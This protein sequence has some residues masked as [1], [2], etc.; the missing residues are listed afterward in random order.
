MLRELLCASVIALCGCNAAQ[1]TQTWEEMNASKAQA[2]KAFNNDKYGM[3]IHWGLYSIPG[4]IWDGKRM[5]ERKGPRVAEWIQLGAKI[6]RAEYAQLAKEFQPHLFNADSIAALAYNAGMKYV[7]ITAKHH[8]GFALYD[9]KV[10]K[11]DC[12]D[13]TPFRRD[14]VKELQDACKRYGLKFGLYYS[15][16]ID[17]MDGND[18]GYEELVASGLP[19]NEK[20]KRKFGA[21]TWDPSPNTYTEYLTRKAYPQVEELLTNYRDLNLLWFDMSHYL[22][23]EQSLAFYQLA[24]KLQPNLLVNS[25]VGNGYGDFEIPGDNKIPQEAQTKPWQTVGTTN[26]SWG[27]KSYDNDWKSHQEILFW[28][29]EIVSRGGNYMLN[30]GPRGDGSVPQQSKDALLSIGQ[31]LKTNGEAIYHTHQ[32]T[33]SHEGPTQIAMKGTHDREKKGFSHH[34]TSRDFW[35]TS[36]GRNIYVISL[37]KPEKE[38][39]VKSITPDACKVKSVSLLGSNTALKWQQTADGLRIQ[40]THPD[41]QLSSYALRV[42]TDE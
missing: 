15:H 6:P 3:F 1:T 27:Y 30:I 9:S 33:I 26:N 24:Y 29:V 14:I 42:V 21:N 8:D 17:W 32:W 19:L 5:E 40:L 12:I 7:V 11:F 37:C 2:I 4:G 22:K 34:F 36:K 25:R 20:A 18:C 41:A 39:F 31:W 35:F 16:C 28:L 10:S 13:A 38:I 23:P